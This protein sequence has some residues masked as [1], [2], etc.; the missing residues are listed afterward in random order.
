M[1]SLGEMIVVVAGAVV[2]SILPVKDV[3]GGGCVM[4]WLMKR[5]KRKKGGREG[6]R[7]DGGVFEYGFREEVKN[8]ERR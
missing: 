8:G 3:W 1:T 2:M 7:R 4:I 6:E 5:R